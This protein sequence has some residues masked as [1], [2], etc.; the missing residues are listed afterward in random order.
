[1]LMNTSVN[2]EHVHFNKLQQ[3]KCIFSSTLMDFGG[4]NV[5]LLMKLMHKCSS[6]ITR[7]YMSAQVTSTYRK[8]I[9]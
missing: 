7:S 6:T 1:M 3:F 8:S 5:Q 2:S 9:V 4:L